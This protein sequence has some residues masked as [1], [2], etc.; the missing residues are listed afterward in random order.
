MRKLNIL[1]VVGMLVT[2]LIHAIMGSLQLMGTAS[3]AHKTVG[4]VLLVLICCHVLVSGILTVK[5]LIAR[6]RS[7][8]GYFKENALFW[9]R[10]IS[11]LTIVFPLIMHLV[12]FKA[13]NADAYRLQEFTTGRLISQILLVAA[14]ALHILINVRPALIVFGIKG[15]KAYAA[16]IL[17]VLSILLLLIAAAFV[18]YYLRWM[19][20]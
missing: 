4:F 3:D 2:F 18:I 13:S 10:R 8:A 20:L 16:D 14:L 19:A 5:T 7:G 17:V 9:A 15:L 11:G 6:K 1:L 12:I